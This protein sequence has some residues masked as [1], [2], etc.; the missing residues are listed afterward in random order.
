MLYIASNM[1]DADRR[2]AEGVLEDPSPALIAREACK[3]HSL[4]R[5][6]ARERPIAVIGVTQTDKSTWVAW[7]FGT[8]EFPKIAKSATRYVKS[9]LLPTLRTLGMLRAEAQSLVDNVDAHAWMRLTGAEFDE[10]LKAFGLNGEDF[11]QYRWR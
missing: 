11:V 4:V 6:F 8:A 2:E 10:D 7:G 9:A 5:M 1:R 3:P